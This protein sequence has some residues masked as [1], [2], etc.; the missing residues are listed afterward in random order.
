M[1]E[2]LFGL[3]PAVI[4]PVVARRVGPARARWLALSALTVSAAEAWRIGLV[5]EVSDD[6]EAALDRYAR[7]FDRIDLRAVAEVKRLAAAHD[8]TPQGYHERAALAF[9]RLLVSAETRAR[10]NRFLAGQ[11]PWPDGGAQ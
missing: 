5:D 1:P 3:I 6:P 8:A 9:E 11:T 2:A 4:L 10:V 7:R